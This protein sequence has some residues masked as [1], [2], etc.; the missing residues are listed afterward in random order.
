MATGVPVT[1]TTRPGGRRS[2]PRAPHT[3]VEPFASSPPGA[4]VS[5][6]ESDDRSPATDHSGPAGPSAPAGP[7]DFAPPVAGPTRP[8][9]AG[10]GTAGGPGGPGGSGG[11]GHS[12][13]G[14]IIGT[15]VVVAAAAA[16]TTWFLRSGSDDSVPGP[17]S[18]PPAGT[19]LGALADVP[20]NG[21]T[22]YPDQQV[23]V[24]RGAGNAVR[25]FS[26]VCTHQRCLVARVVGGEIDCPCHG[27]AF[28]A[29]TGAVL[30]GPAR[31]ALTPV[32]VT[33][34]NGSVVTA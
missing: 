5:T 15:G 7:G 12:R 23:V 6:F 28:D 3:G 8:A 18:V 22:V 14:L 20:A 32:P 1:K 29:T 17:D 24:T 25:A 30:R 21:G 19:T 13:R 10:S 2:A 34:V 33:V 27:S 16:G 11:P 4:V 31:L 9:A 26:A